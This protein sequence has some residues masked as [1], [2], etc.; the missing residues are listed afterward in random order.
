MR[1]E[2]VNL[3]FPEPLPSVEEIIAKYPKRELPE[4][5]K[6]TRV[7]PSPTGYFHVGNLSA[8]LISERLAH[9]SGGVI[10]VRIED[11]D[12]K[13]QVEGAVDI[14]LR[15]LRHFDIFNDEGPVFEGGEKGAYGPYVQSQRRHIYHAFIKDWLLKDLAYLCFCT[16]EENQKIHDMQSKGNIRPGYYGAFAKCRKLTEDEILE[17]LKAGKKYVVRFKSPGHYTKKIVIEDVLRGRR[18][19]PENDL[20]IPIMK[21]DGLPTY[22]FAHLIDDHLMGTTHVLRGEEWLSSLPLHIQLFTA[23]GWKPPKYGHISHIQKM[24]GENRRK[25]SKRLDPEANMTYYDEQGYPTVAVL[26]YLMNIA[27]S[28][29]EDWR[30]QNPTTDYREFP[31]NMKKLN[32]SGALFDFVKLN[33]ISRDVIGRMSATEVYALAKEWMDK[34]DVPFAKMMEANKEYMISILSIEREG[35]KK[36]RKDMTIWKDMKEMVSFFFD[37]L[38]TQTTGEAY[39]ALSPMPVAEI[40]NILNDFKGIYDENDDKDVWFDKVKQVAAKNGYATDMK[41]YKANPDEYKGSVADVAKVLR[42]FVTGKEQSPDLH[43]VMQVMG[44]ERVMKRLNVE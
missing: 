40:T 23:M 12:Q 4:G 35:V 22:H 42:I 28:N 7:G 32:A 17:N 27:N 14:L 9:Q 33:S 19:F 16:E 5:A 20:D 39:K 26:E 31:F 38:F 36:V 8:A 1:E 11:T 34:Y 15:S 41:V 37:N 18:E 25:L 13:R 30:R 6:V 21:S 2:I 3:V 44:K 43:A 29:F 10:F 24:D